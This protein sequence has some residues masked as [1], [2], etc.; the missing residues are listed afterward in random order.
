MDGQVC[1]CVAYMNTWHQDALWEEGKPAEGSVMHWA[2][3]CCQTLGSAIRVDV[4]LT[5]TTY[6]SIVAEHVY[7][8]METVFPDGCGLFQQDNVPCQK[9]VRNG[10]QMCWTNK[11][12]PWKTHLA[13]YRT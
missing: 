7:P 3:F 4:S 5:H 8:F 13:T 12:D 10:L 9:W 6:L 1:V 2:I 11:S